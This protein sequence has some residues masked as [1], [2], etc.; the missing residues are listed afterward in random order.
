VN[1]TFRDKNIKLD[2]I[3]N[4][5]PHSLASMIQAIELYLPH[6]A[7][8]GI[9]VV[10]DIQ[11]LDWIRALRTVMPLQDQKFVDIFNLRAIKG[12]YDDIMFII[13]RTL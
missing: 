4:D 6:L 5:G 10:E 2:I 9:F 1:N 7:E 8:D 13:N 12:L 3:V 11:R